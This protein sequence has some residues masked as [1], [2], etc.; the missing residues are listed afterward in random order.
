MV[1]ERFSS[2]RRTRSF[3]PVP[4]D[5]FKKQNKLNILI[6]GLPMVKICGSHVQPVERFGVELVVA[7][8]IEPLRHDR[9]C[10]L[11]NVEPMEHLRHSSSNC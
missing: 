4:S 6:V 11:V 8:G 7:G 5:S 9:R 3:C 2:S 1:N 10:L